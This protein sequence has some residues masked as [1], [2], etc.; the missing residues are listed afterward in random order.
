MILAVTIAALPRF[1]LLWFLCCS[2]QKFRSLAFPAL[3]VVSMLLLLEALLPTER[4]HLA[5]DG[6]HSAS[7][8]LWKPIKT[9]PYGKTLWYSLLWAVQGFVHES[10]D[11]QWPGSMGGNVSKWESK[12]TFVIRSMLIEKK[13]R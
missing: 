6:L 11:Q 12:C 13:R 8:F 10:R 9:M 5:A 4:M 2:Y 3:L 7:F 1:L